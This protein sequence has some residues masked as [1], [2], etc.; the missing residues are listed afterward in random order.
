MREVINTP[1][2]GVAITIISYTL[3]RELYRRIPFFLFNPLLMAPLAIIL[4][5]WSSHT[6]LEAYNQGGKIISYFLGPATVALGVPLYRQLPLIRRHWR[7]ILAGIV[8]GSVAGVI[9]SV[10]IARLLGASTVTLLSVAAK[11]T[12]APIAVGITEKLGGAPAITAFA[13]AV[14]GILGGTLGP[15]VLR[16]A[17]VKHRVAR[18]IAIGTASHAGGTSRAMQLGEVEGSMSGAAIVLTGTVTA[19]VVTIL[20]HWLIAS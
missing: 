12:T 14:T 4:L 10:L 17:R 5:L 1:V 8:S 11:S 18:G 9:S 13:V 6:P 16:L 3:A 2:F 20:I 19:L 7:P 15:E